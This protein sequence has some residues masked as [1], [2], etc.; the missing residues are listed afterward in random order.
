M[1]LTIRRSGTDGFCRVGQSLYRADELP[2]IAQSMQGLILTGVG[3][4]STLL[5]M[6]VASMSELQPFNVSER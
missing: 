3:G 6:L 1:C 2:R 5:T 4:L